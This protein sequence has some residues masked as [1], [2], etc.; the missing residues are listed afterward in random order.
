MSPR[1]LASL[2]PASPSVRGD[3]VGLSQCLT[4][5][6]SCSWAHVSRV[7]TSS[8]ASPGGPWCLTRS[9]HLEGC[10]PREAQAGPGQTGETWAGRAHNGALSGPR[11]TLLREHDSRQSHS[12]SPHGPALPLRELFHGCPRA[13]ELMVSRA[14]ARKPFIAAGD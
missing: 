5:Q 14:I 7:R 9:L 1:P 8:W 6:Q 4:Q 13:H 10:Q 3:N 12:P 11:D 2:S